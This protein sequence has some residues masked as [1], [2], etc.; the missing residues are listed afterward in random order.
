MPV[1]IWDRLRTDL[2]HRRVDAVQQTLASATEAERALVAKRL[3]TYVRTEMPDPD[4]GLLV[5]ADD[6]YLPGVAVAAVGC[7]PSDVAVA[8]LLNRAA[9]R[10][11]VIHLP[12]DRLVDVAR[13]RGVPW[14]GGLAERLAANLPNN[15]GPDR[16]RVVA[17]LV[18][19]A[20]GPVPTGDAFVTGWVEWLRGQG[21]VVERLVWGPFLDPLIPRL[22]EIDG[23]GLALT[24]PRDSSLLDALVTLTR[25]GR[26]KQ[27]SMLDGCLARLHHPDRPGAL[28]CFTALHTRLEPTVG[29]LAE[30]AAGYAEL[31]A[32][33]PSPV[34]GFAQQQL[35]TL[36]TAGRLDLDLLLDASRSVLERPEKVVVRA[37]LTLLER[38]ARGHP[39]RVVEILVAVSAV[40]GHPV[41]D[42]QRRGL[43]LVTRH[44]A[45]LTGAEQAQLAA[46][47]SG[48]SADLRAKAQTLLP[49]GGSTPRS[50]LPEVVEAAPREPMPPPV[51]T[52]DELRLLLAGPGLNT[53][54]DR[55]RMMAALAR[56]AE[57]DPASITALIEARVQQLRTH[58]QERLDQ[59]RQWTGEPEQR[60]SFAD[61]GRD[62]ALL[63]AAA[64][65]WPISPLLFSHPEFAQYRTAFA[66]VRDLVL[67]QESPLEAEPWTSFPELLIPLRTAELGVGLGEPR[68]VRSPRM[69]LSTPTD[70]SGR[71]DPAV[72]LDRIATA[73]AEGRQ[74]YPID[75]EQALLRLPRTVD[76][77]IVVA[78]GALR[79]PA[80]T[81]LAR[82]LGDGGPAEPAA[83]VRGG[84]RPQEGTYRADQ[85]PGGNRHVVLTL[86]EEPRS[87]L[88][89]GLFEVNPKRIP[90]ASWRR[91]EAPPMDAL[92][93]YR[94]VVAAWALTDR[95]AVS[96]GTP[97]GRFGRGTTVRDRFGRAPDPVGAGTTGELLPTGRDV[98]GPAGPAL[99]LVLAYT[100]GSDRVF[101][102][103]GAVDALIS[104][105]A[106]GNLDGA[107]LGEQLGGLIA[108]GEIAFARIPP[109][110]A[111]AARAGAAAVVWDVVAALLPYVLGGRPTGL[112]DLLTL[113]VDLATGLGRRDQIPG[114][115]EVAARKG[116]GGTVN[117]ARRL[118]RVLAGG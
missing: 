19:A 83:T 63:Y 72:L 102:R 76:P 1:S 75:L 23:L 38:A 37:Q 35:T 65:R 44:A 31:S 87:G 54:I 90:G 45:V 69:L 36:Q 86:S 2:D 56:F 30:R 115:N 13:D 109:S 67:N 43:A 111:E 79:S 74:S 80:G 107:A 33:A 96:N 66:N 26:L 78:A 34:A 48:L 71:I 108:D 21:D 88:H 20:K 85:R 51:K 53:W 27:E 77:G 91:S 59:N 46:A 103:A 57:D 7:L 100:L 39:N 25:K 18:V 82:W 84:R 15:A 17:D 41:F 95:D 40:F 118:K 47:A 9:V 49:V 70:V 93:D 50:S 104:L 22:F 105:A 106:A 61:H 73:E 12:V 32:I 64:T 116:S 62:T 114:L 58:E 117:Q 29:E 28:R 98:G 94:E 42:L 60:H 5:H 110:L 52:V 89:R 99:I 97:G 24:D 68:T 101:R 14:L 92:P 113:G 16:W 10:P 81:A 55:E 8:T 112:P 3:L 4:W 11:H 6:S